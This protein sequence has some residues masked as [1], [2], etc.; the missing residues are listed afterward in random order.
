MQYI[1][2]SD[3]AFRIFSSLISNGE[4][5][6]DEPFTIKIGR[7]GYPEIEHGLLYM[8]LTGDLKLEAVFMPHSSKA[9]G[10]Q[11]WE[12]ITNST[13]LYEL[14]RNGKSRLPKRSKKERER[15][16]K[17]YDRQMAEKEFAEIEMAKQAAEDRRNFINAK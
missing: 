7:K 15:A 14:I 13:R 2:S 5:I 12:R 16:Q 8:N 10:S 6:G 9:D 11:N 4:D 1:N 3:A 17:R